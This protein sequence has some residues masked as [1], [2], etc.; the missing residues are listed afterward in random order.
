MIYLFPTI[1]PAS[2]LLLTSGLKALCGT[3]TEGTRP[4]RR[5]DPAPLLMQIQFLFSPV[6]QENA[7]DQDNDCH[8]HQ[9]RGGGEGTCEV[10]PL[11]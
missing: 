5:F 8:D 2:R 4:D 6:F 7:E 9:K 3:L 1:L 11:V 10:I